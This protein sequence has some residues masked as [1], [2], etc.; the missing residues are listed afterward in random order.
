MPR[1]RTEI[2]VLCVLLLAGAMIA[3][4]AAA[5]EIP[6]SSWNKL[7]DN[8]TNA[9]DET[10]IIITQDIDMKGGIALSTAKTITLVPGGTD[11]ITLITNF[12]NTSYMFA[13]TNGNLMMSNNSSTGKILILDGIKDSSYPLVVVGN[14]RN[15]TLND[16]YLYNVTALQG[17][18]VWVNNGGTFVMHGGTI[19]DNMVTGNGGGVYVDTG[20]KFIMNDGVIANN[21]ATKGSGVHMVGNAIF[22]MNGG[23][24][25]KNNATSTRWRSACADRRR[26]VHDDQ[27]S[28]CKQHRTKRRWSVSGKRQYWCRR[29]QRVHNDRRSCSVQSCTLRRR[30]HRGDR[31]RQP[32]HDD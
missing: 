9:V 26:Q 25:A 24:I 23:T 7:K 20:G 28:D 8:I 3:A 27:W 30:R 14:Q 11:N 10:T 12:S 15:F 22:T 16:G 19:A 2:M 29:R 31:Q 1:N 21:T 6:V 18:G 5:V 32:C 4:P 17:G 13:V